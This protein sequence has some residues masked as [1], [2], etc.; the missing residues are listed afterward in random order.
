MMSD[1][2]DQYRE[3]V[4]N[5]LLA[6]THIEY[7]KNN[8][9]LYT[10]ITIRFPYLKYPMDIVHKPVFGTKDE[11]PNQLLLRDILD[12][13]HTKPFRNYPMEFRFEME[14]YSI[15]G[16]EVQLMWDTYSGILSKMVDADHCR[17]VQPLGYVWNVEDSDPCPRE[18]D[19]VPNWDDF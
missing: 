2:Q 13:L 11:L 17:K 1:K 7:R 15:Y 8:E 3:Y 12:Q 19:Y 6:N 10:N 18:Y 4:V 14:Q 9:L 5:K 16:D